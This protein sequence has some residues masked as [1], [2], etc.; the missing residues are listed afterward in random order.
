MRYRA[1]EVKADRIIVVTDIGQ[2]LHF[3][4]IAAGALKA[5]FIDPAKTQ[6]NH[7]PFGMVL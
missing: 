1:N 4:L 7:M 3:K 6:F 5:G 2:E